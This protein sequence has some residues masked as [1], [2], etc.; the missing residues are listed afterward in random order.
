M[1]CRVSLLYHLP[2]CLEMDHHPGAAIAALMKLSFD[3][4]YRH[5]ICT[6]GGLQAIAELLEVENKAATP[7]NDYR[8][9]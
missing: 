7:M 4:D 1:K 3:E 6:L 2:D 5:A 8:Y 9:H